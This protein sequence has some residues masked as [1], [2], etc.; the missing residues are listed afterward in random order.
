MNLKTGV[1]S[2]V[3]NLAFRI[4]AILMLAIL[5]LSA[6][7][8]SAFACAAVPPPSAYPQYTLKER[9]DHVSYVFSGTITNIQ[10]GNTAVATVDVK[11]Y[12]KGGGPRTVKISG[13]STGA[14]CQ[15]SVQVGQQ[16]VFFVQGDPSRGFRATNR[17]DTANYVDPTEK[18]TDQ[19]L[20]ELVQATGHQPT[21][22]FTDD[23][24]TPGP[25][26][27]NPPSSGLNLEVTGTVVGAIA[28]V[29]VIVMTLGGRFFF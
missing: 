4:G 29:F 3:N 7:V 24:I 27:K 5:T 23:V 26:V 12:Y 19:F 20:A 25:T 11:Q 16:A 8:S 6:N 13:F 10:Y 14:D 9:A 1:A 2:L 28:I 18:I 15:E 21:Y 22:P 17:L